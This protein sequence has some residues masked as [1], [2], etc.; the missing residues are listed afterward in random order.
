MPQK[1]IMLGWKM[2]RHWEA[3]VWLFVVILFALACSVI[4]AASGHNQFGAVVG[5]LIGGSVFGK[6]K[7]YIAER[8]Y[9][10]VLFKSS[11]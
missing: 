5:G 3:W 1:R 8:Y 7:R 9:R 6:V 2:Y 4:G 11:L 10:D